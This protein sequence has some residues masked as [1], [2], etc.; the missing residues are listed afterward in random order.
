MTGHYQETF[1]KLI[2]WQKAKE[3]A[4]T[5]Y[6]LTQSFPKGELY[7]LVSQMRRAAVSVMSNLA[8]GNQRKGLKDRAHFFNIAY[9]SLTELD[10]QS[11]LAF[12][13]KFIKAADHKALQDEIN[14]TGFF[15]FKLSESFKK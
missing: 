1:R 3:L 15:I 4:K 6:R 12:E 14:T 11:E 5:V 2:A 13:L 10:S 7:G 9:S 8:E